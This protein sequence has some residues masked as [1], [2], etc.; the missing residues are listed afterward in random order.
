MSLF[1]LI[2][3]VTQYITYM[4]LYRL[5]QSKT[6][7]YLFPLEKILFVFFANCQ[8]LRPGDVTPSLN[9]SNSM[10]NQALF[11]AEHSEIILSTV[12]EVRKVMMSM[13]QNLA[14]C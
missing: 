14:H 13:Q 3:W 8:L 9:G 6:K 4:K 1:L 10:D 12:E 11:H 5:M 7:T 2:H